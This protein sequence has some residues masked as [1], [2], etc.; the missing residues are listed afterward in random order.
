MNLHLPLLAAANPMDHVVDAPLFEGILW[1]PGDASFWEGLFTTLASV[2]LA[3]QTFM[4][5]LAGA[6][7][8]LFFWSYA[9][10]AA[11]KPVPGRW[12]NFVEWLLDFLKMQMLRPFL[13]HHGDKYLPLI[14]TL[15][16]YILTCNLLGLVP[17]FDFLGHGGS[18]A[19]GN[20]WITAGL[21]VCAFFSYHALGI[22]EQGFL[23]Y[24]KNFVPPVPAYILP[25]II[26][27]EVVAHVVRPCAL[28]IRLYANMLAGH[29]MIA[30]I[31]GF[32]VILTHGN[33]ALGV[34]VSLISMLAVT[35]LTFLELLVALVQ[36]FVFAFLTTVFLSMAVHPEH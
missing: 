19:T 27:V 8:L 4:F 24:M 26:P 21:A 22:R 34:P 23:H 35:A 14:A 20:L 12:G 2:G 16:V 5:L 31:L 18:T 9:R 36:A 17:F 15:F 29:I 32:T 25:I 33:L 6:L 3:K 10:R 7:T 13:G 30:A 11:E 28:A 1:H